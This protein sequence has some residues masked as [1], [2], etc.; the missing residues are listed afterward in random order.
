MG[1]GKDVSEVVPRCEGVHITDAWRP[2]TYT[3]TTDNIF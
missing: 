2:S 1:R 3:V